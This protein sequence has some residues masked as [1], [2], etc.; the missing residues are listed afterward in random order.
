MH[1]QGRILELTDVPQSCEIARRES[2]MGR[3]LSNSVRFLIAPPP[4]DLNT[5]MCRIVDSICVR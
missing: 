1:V 4:P 5:Y 2:E 3:E